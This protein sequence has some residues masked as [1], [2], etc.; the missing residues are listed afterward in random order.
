MPQSTLSYARVVEGLA[1]PP[2][3]EG[4]RALLFEFAK[5]EITAIEADA[6]TVEA[7]PDRLDLLSEGGLR[8]YLEGLLRV[9]TGIPHFHAEHALP[10][11]VVVRADRSVETLRP[12]IAAVRVDPPEGR[13]LDA[14]L[15]TEAIRVQE[16][17]HATLG[18]NRA[19]ASLG[20]YP[21]ARIRFPLD[22]RMETVA[23]LAFHPLDGEAPVPGDVFF[24]D[25]PL[26][27][28][29]GAL[30]RVDDKC[31]VLRDS[32]EAI[33]S[34]P[35]VLN[36][37]VAGEARAGDGALLIE[38]TGQ[39]AARVE[40]AIGLLSLPFVARGWRVAPIPVEYPDHR[41]TGERLVRPRAVH[42]SSTTLAALSGTELLPHEV[43]ESL[44]RCRLGAQSVADG[45]T[46]EVPPWRPDIHASVDLI[47]D[48]LLIRGLAGLGRHLPPSATRGRRSD[49][50]QLAA[51]LTDRFLGMGFVP[52]FTTV[53]VSEGL[54]ATL[55]AE[56]LAIRNPVSS[57][58]SRVRSSLQIALLGALT[59]NVRHAYPQRLSEVGPV[60]V[61]SNSA[62][63][64]VRTTDHAAFVIAADGTGFADVAAII[65][66]LLRRFQV[67]GV[68]EPAT[69]PATIPGR[70]ARLRLA[71]EAIAE[72]GEIHPQVLSELGIPV[73]VAWG[74]I[75]LTALRPLLAA[76]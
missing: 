23:P 60:V 30:G 73:P 63:D 75:D 15:L 17:L 67:T 61:R 8:M 42:L 46:A 76:E 32:A 54:Q 74:E 25:H 68:R 51:R 70:A 3:P 65:D 71:G 31:L 58:Y 16:I 56:A 49:R 66:H 38:G 14:G 41:S 2:D 7:T 33:L 10:S 55:G 9:R 26:A 52:L 12:T 39:R 48:L 50:S 57:E 27:G 21:W 22:Y 4:L 59:R 28:R 72:M 11:E 45:W 62:E 35:P 37:R 34:L 20:I 1:Q 40:E 18:L 24:R 36:S 29:Y 19:A 5:A 43:V 6:I 13:S 64:P 69:L 53:L 44:E 47:E